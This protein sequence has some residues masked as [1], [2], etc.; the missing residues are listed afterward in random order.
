MFL[1]L[2]V[3]G[4]L[5]IRYNLGFLVIVLVVSILLFV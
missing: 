3:L 4:V 1:N 5:G 2:H